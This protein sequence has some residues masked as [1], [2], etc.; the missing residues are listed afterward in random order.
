MQG[1]HAATLLAALMDMHLPLRRTLINT[2][3]TVVL[4]V[5]GC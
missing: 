4:L 3:L 1:W 2:D 5:L